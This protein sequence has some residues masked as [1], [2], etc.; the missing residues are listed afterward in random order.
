MKIAVIDDRAQ[1]RDIIGKYIEQYMEKRLMT[2]ETVNFESGE[3]FLKSFADKEY[4][5]VFL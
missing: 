1:D 4:A 2:Y 3:A 5:M